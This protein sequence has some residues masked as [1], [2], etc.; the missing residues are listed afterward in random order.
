MQWTDRIRQVK[1]ILVVAAVIIAV[2]SLLVSHFLVRDLSIEERHRM[3]VWAQALHALNKADETTDVSL[4]LSVMEGNNTI[5]VIVVNSEGDIDDFRNIKDIDDS[6]ESMAN[7]QKLK[8][9]ARRMIKAGDTIRIGQQLVCYDESIMLKRLQ[10]WPYVQLG[11]VLIFVVVAIFAL[12]SS[13]RAEQNKVWVGLSK[14]T[15]H[16]LGTPVSSLMAWVEM[17]KEQYPQDDLLPEMDKDVKRLQLIADRFSKIGSLPEP[18]DASMNDVLV[19]VIDY[20]DRRTSSQ[21]QMIR[22]LPDHEVIVKMNASLFEWVVENLCKNAVDAMEGKG[23]ITLTLFDEPHQVVIEVQDTGKGIKKK[24]L[25]SVFTPGFTTKKRGWGL[26]L[27]LAK[28]IVEE[29]HKGRIFVK[30][31]EPGKGTTFRIEMKK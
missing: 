24:D 19:H 21:V 20:M 8:D 30:Q 28:R 14:E 9:Y 1:I 2:A 17:L 10:A 13:K 31:S 16:Q 29:Y 11:I 15:A 3:E 26:G 27:S 12:L 22:H 7:S 25:N 18:V 23:T 6:Q 4:V 5:P